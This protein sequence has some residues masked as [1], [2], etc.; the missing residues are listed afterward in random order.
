MNNSSDDNRYNYSI[1]IPH[2]NQPQLLERC[3]RSI[4]RR[5]DIQILIIDD[6]SNSDKVNFNQFP[7]SNDP[8]IEIIFTQEGKGAGYAR[9][10]GL[11]HARGK[12]LLFA[13]SDDYFTDNAFSF[14]DQNMSLSADVLYFSYGIIDCRLNKKKRH[15]HRGNMKELIQYNID[16]DK[17]KLVSH[18]WSPRAKMFLRSFVESNKIR[19]EET[20]KMNDAYFIISAGIKASNVKAIIGTVYIYTINDNSI[21]RSYDRRRDFDC[22]YQRIKINRLFIQNGYAIFILL[23]LK[24]LLSIFRRHGFFSLLQA[25]MAILK[26]KH[27]Y[28]CFLLH[29]AVLITRIHR[30]VIDLCISSLQKENEL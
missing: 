1:I 30:Q 9:N 4:P 2:K 14:F 18:H 13:D 23:Y 28:D 26:Y 12:W 22:L 17:K 3:L 19:F 21:V 8:F 29:I 10:V 15:R 27:I 24:V 16:H 25:I 20:M 5:N 11:D 6:N 7:G